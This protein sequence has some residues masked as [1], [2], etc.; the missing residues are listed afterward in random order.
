MGLDGKRF[1]CGEDSKTV[2][3]LRKGNSSLLSEVFALLNCKR[4]ER[5]KSAIQ[6]QMKSKGKIDLNRS[7]S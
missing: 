5:I 1:F 7:I 3:R 6:K 4:V 2:L